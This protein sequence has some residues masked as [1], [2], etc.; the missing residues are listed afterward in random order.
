VAG[1]AIDLGEEDLG[2][3]R[4]GAIGTAGGGLGGGACSR[5]IS[6]GEEDAPEPHLCARPV[7]ALGGHRA[8]GGG[9]VAVVAVEELVVA[10]ADV[11]SSPGRQPQEQ[12]R[13]RQGSGQSG[14]AE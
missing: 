8:V 2:V 6:D 7:L 4:R 1:L 3:R 11:S 10:A 9:R 12:R 5:D 14:H 13:Q